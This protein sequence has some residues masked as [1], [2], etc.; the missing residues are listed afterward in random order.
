MVTINRLK[1]PNGD[2]CRADRIVTKQVQSVMRRKVQAGQAQ[3]QAR[4]VSV[5]K[6]LRLTLS[7][8]GQELFS[9]ALAAIGAKQEKIDAAACAAVFDDDQLLILL[10]GPDGARGAVMIDPSLVGGLI[11]QQTMG[12]VRPAPDGAS[13]VMTGTDAS[14]VAPLINALLDRAALLPET[15]E[16]RSILAHYRFGAKAGDVRLLMLALEAPEHHLIRLTV[17]MAKGAR[18][19]EI[20]FCLPVAQPLA[21]EHADPDEFDT[22]LPVRSLADTMMSLPAKLMV[23]LCEVTLPVSQVSA[24][25][26]G[27]VI[28]LG[29]VSF[30][31]ARIRTIDNRV[32]AQAVLGQSNGM[33]AVRLKSDQPAG[34]VP[35][36]GEDDAH[37][38]LIEHGAL[39]TS[40]EATYAAESLQAGPSAFKP[41]KIKEDH[42][43]PDMSDLPAFDD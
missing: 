43:M 32:L 12:Q 17:D 39:G 26:V 1:T 30:Q 2:K 38:M 14:L 11:Q 4:T 20:V 41:S 6:A 22:V 27:Q 28:D 35:Q 24:L 23:S 37:K 19:G 8:V 42:A 31:D 10:D 40:F 36:R 9:L 25:R 15:E 21:V 34:P 18:K 3:H 13:R 33:R 7:K 29:I 16:E 5:L